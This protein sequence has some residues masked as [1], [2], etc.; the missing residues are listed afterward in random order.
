[1]GPLRQE[2]CKGNTFPIF[3]PTNKKRGTSISSLSV[4]LINTNTVDCVTFNMPYSAAWNP[5]HVSH[6]FTTVA[7]AVALENHSLI[8]RT[9]A[10]SASTELLLPC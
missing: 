7:S 6:D 1:M 4:R 8:N 2:E 3:N 10:G 9:A 5:K